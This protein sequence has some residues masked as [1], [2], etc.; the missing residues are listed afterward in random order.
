[1]YF[2]MDLRGSPFLIDGR[3]RLYFFFVG[4]GNIF[5]PVTPE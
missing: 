2:A 1:M 5:I 3:L 4:V